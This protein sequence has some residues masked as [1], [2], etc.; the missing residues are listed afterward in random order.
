MS[1]FPLVISILFAITGLLLIAICLKVILQALFGDW[2]SWS[3]KA[4][5][6]RREHLVEHLDVL[7]EKEQ[8]LEGVK[9]LK[10]GF[11][12][13]DV[14]F[15]SDLIESA[16]NL[17][18]SLLSRAVLISQKLGKH[19]SNLAIVEDLFLSRRDLMR[20]HL[21][22]CSTKS[23]LEKKKEP[24]TPDWALC[25]YSSKL[26]EL[27]DCLATNRKSLESQLEQLFH[28]LLDPREPVEITYH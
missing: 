1:F 22:A 17:N 10:S 15:N 19:I 16:S 28:A 25:E 27:S 24:Q 6:T 8:W 21:E 12:T 26:S 13:D 18:L 7:I 5:L 11:F 3:A 14:R 9:V 4:T 2:R 20:S 23:M